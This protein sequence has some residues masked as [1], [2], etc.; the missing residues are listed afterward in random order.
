MLHPPGGTR[1]YEIKGP[2]PNESE[3]KCRLAV[4]LQRLKET[5]IKV[6]VVAA[7]ELA[8][9]F[10]E[11]SCNPFVEFFWSASTTGPSSLETVWDLVWVTAPKGST[12]NPSWD[13]EDGAIAFLPPI[14]TSENAF[15]FNSAAV[16]GIRKVE[17]GCWIPRNYDAGLFSSTRTKAIVALIAANQECEEDAPQVNEAVEE[18][19]NHFRK[20]AMLAESER[21]SMWQEEESMRATC[22]KGF[23]EENKAVMAEQRLFLKE[24]S[25]LQSD[26]RHTSNLVARLRFVLAE[27]LDS[28]SVLYYC[29][30]PATG[31]NLR[32]YAISVSSTEDE[33]E[34]RKL[35]DAIVYER[36]S[37]VVKVLEFSVHSIRAFTYNGI[38]TRAARVGLAVTEHDGGATL[39]DFIR[40][41]GATMSS[42][43]F[44]SLVRG[45]AL[46]MKQLHDLGILHR[47][48]HVGSFTVLPRLSPETCTLD[49]LW[50]FR[51]SRQEGWGCSLTRPP[52]ANNGIISDKSDVFALGVSVYFLATTSRYITQISPL[53]Y[54]LSEVL[55]TVPYR[56]S[57]WVNPILKMCLEPNPSS[58]PSAGDLLV[59][60]D[61]P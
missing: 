28:G 4:K 20:Q 8:K 5:M 23:Y 11:I 55:R 13:A 18:L 6:Q 29:I 21:R 40:E 54:P 48:I 3:R 34:L 31:R 58:R 38:S 44:K 2:N 36:P 52:E 59:Y 57:D 45:A 35:F 19:L 12:G 17:G 47:N 56:W 46:G 37:A 14:W 49:D 32:L 30:D 16:N 27:S 53:N 25:S 7:K 10:D 50:I 24:F 39:E 43:S 26:A 60:L 9:K 33:M 42:E 61:S 15:F 22:F 51:N 41:K 1:Y